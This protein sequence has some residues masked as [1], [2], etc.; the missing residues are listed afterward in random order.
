MSCDGAAQ[1]SRQ[2]NCSPDRG[3]GNDIDERASRQNGSKRDQHLFPGLHLQ[4]GV[5]RDQLLDLGEGTI[6]DRQL[7]HGCIRAGSG[8]TPASES[9]V[10]LA[11]DMNRILIS[12]FR[13]LDQFHALYLR[14]LKNHEIGRCG[15]I[16]L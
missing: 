2:Q 13:A 15:E 9:L 10:A 8:R 14:R 7:S 12:L 1:V 11:I 5:P 6:N 16:I 4:Q 3:T